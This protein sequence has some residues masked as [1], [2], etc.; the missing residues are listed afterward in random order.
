MIVPAVGGLASGL[1]N[2]AGNL[3]TGSP[4]ALSG[5]VTPKA[6]AAGLGQTAGTSGIEGVGGIEGAGGVEGAGGGS[7]FGSE[8]TNAISSLEGSQQSAAS[9][10][11]ALA[12]GSVSDPEAAVTTVEDASLEMQLAAQIRTKATE[13]A[14]TIFQTQV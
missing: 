11:Q 13:A 9:A 4:E 2:A 6:G 3:A 10:S 7:S 14:Q 5:A 1:G 12:T 8:L